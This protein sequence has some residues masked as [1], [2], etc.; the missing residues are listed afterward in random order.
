MRL[1]DPST[2]DVRILRS[3]LNEIGNLC[4]QDFEYSMC[5]FIVEVVKIKNGTDYP[6][7][8]LYQLCVAIQKFLF[9]K[10]LKWKLIEGEFDK[11]RTV[12]DNT[13]KERAQQSIGTTVK[14]AQ[15][16]GYEQEKHMWDSGILGE[17]NP[18]KLRDTVLFLIGLNIGLQ[19]GD[20]Q[21]NLRHNGDI[22]SQL[23]FKRNNKGVHCLVYTEDSVTKTNDGGLS[24]MNKECKIV[25]VY[26]SEDKTKCPI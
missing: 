6:G 8:T 24:S 9:S 25:W 21:Y 12:L 20:E 2:Y 22:P 18:E 1:S 16:L 5:R 11:L 19:A 7:C 26:P 23:Q 13:M 14:R 17:D 15:M 3:D 10:G 4:K